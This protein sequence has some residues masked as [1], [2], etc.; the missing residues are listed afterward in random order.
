MR[1][2]GLERFASVSVSIRTLSWLLTQGFVVHLF[3]RVGL[4][5]GKK[6]QSISI[7]CEFVYRLHKFA[8][9]NHVEESFINGF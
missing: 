4:L 6:V 3:I 7:S 9:M 8:G 1:F 5:V 2:G